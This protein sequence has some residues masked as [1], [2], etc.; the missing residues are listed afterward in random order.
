MVARDRLVAYL[1]ELLD[2]GAYEDY[3]PQGLQVEGKPHVSRI[4]TGVSA[5]LDLFR[6]AEAR[7]A[8][9][10]IVHHGLFWDQESRTVR[11][12][13][14]KRLAILLKN[15]ISLVAYH[16]PLDGHHGIGN[17]ALAARALGLIALE[18][19]ATVG[20]WGRLAEPVDYRV[21]FNKVKILYESNPLV[22][23]YGPT[24]V[25]AIGIV[26]GGGA[27]Y[28][29]EA[30][31]LGLHVFITGEAAE[32][33]MHLAKESGVHFIAAGHYATERLGI[34]K[35]GEQIAQEFGIE[36]EFV[37]LPNPV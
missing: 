18:R 28:L 32:V 20:Y 13:M 25:E 3:G 22:F 35:L 24:S 17:N 7:G 37:D 19:F 10:I 30:I 21:I 14:K 5:S 34:K 16:L 6:Q 27:R 2:P 8:D 4:V 15:D 9:M 26:S 36:V 11:G 31:E 33:S 1:N 29:Q 23:D 12:A